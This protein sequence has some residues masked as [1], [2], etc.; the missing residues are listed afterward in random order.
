MNRRTSLVIAIVG[1]FGLL[2]VAGPV[3]AANGSVS[4]KEADER[5]SFSPQMVYVNVGES[6]TWTNDSD[7][8]HTVTSDSGDE[9]ASE[10]LAEDDTFDH[11]FS[12]TGT[13]AYH[14]TIH[15]YMKGS[16]VVLAAGVTPP[17]T[18]T[19]QGSTPTQEPVWLGIALLVLAAVV[20]GGLAIRRIRQA[21]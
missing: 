21:G 7:A 10:N 3:L 17:A 5:Y 13:F 6:V 18:E 20:A 1:L 16:V 11:R 4:I 15:A 8:P 12:A 14:C 19:V 9:L 2:T